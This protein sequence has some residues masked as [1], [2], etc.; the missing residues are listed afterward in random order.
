MCLMMVTFDVIMGPQ[1]ET[2]DIGFLSEL[3]LN[4]F[5]IGRPYV[6]GKQ[7]PHARVPRHPIL[8]F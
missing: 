3:L 2:G 1:D 4:A 7:H 5:L 6:R 8:T